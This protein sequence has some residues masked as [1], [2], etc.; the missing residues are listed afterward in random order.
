M[1]TPVTD[2]SKKEAHLVAEYLTLTSNQIYKFRCELNFSRRALCFIGNS[3][4]QKIIS[5]DHAKKIA[6]EVEHGISTESSL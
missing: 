2:I 3:G 1:D 4:G 5:F 6:K